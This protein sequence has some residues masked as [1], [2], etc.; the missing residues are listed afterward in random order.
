M[1]S[2]FRW[3]VLAVLWSGGATAFAQDPNRFVFLCFGQSNMEGFPGIEA[4]DQGPVDERFQVLAAVDF[5]KSGR[6]KGSWY[7]ALPPLSRP[8]AGLGPAD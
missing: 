1:K 4:Q 6:V 5:P 2:L 3:L 8:A 7:P